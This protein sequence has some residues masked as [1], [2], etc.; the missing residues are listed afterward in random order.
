MRL[1]YEAFCRTGG[2]GQPETYRALVI[3]PGMMVPP[4]VSVLSGVGGCGRPAP[5]VAAA[6]VFASTST[7]GDRF[8]VYFLG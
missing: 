6:D 7:C 8:M 1:S 3:I 5:V 4:H 2:E